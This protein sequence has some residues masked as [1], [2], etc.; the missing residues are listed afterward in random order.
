V[1]QSIFGKD[2]TQEDVPKKTFA[3]AFALLQ[4]FRGRTALN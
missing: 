2:L 4:K 1:R 3:L